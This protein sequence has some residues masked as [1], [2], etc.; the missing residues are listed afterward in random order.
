[1]APL[2]GT[3]DVKKGAKPEG[4]GGGATTVAGRLHPSRVQSV[5]RAHFSDVRL[6]YEAGLK[7][8]A[9]LQGRV[10]VKFTIGRDGAVTSAT[11]HGSDLPDPDVVACVLDVFRKL[12]FQPP[13]RGVVIVTYPLT[14]QPG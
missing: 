12:R 7:R 6:C 2:P 11:D 13:Q 5:V 10:H 1:M 14:L 3:S 8:K 4:I 9:D